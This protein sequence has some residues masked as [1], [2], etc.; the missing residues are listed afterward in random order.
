VADGVDVVVIGG[1][2]NGLVAG[3][4][5]AR[6]RRSVLVIEQRPVP[7]GA[8]VTTEFSPGFRAP[9]LSHSLGPIDRAVIRELALDGIG[10]GFVSPEPALTTLGSRGELI[11]FHKDPVRTAESIRAVSPPDADAWPAFVESVGRVGAVAAAVTRRP[12][13]PLDQMTAADAWS[14]LR[15]ARQA[16]GLGRRDLAR[17]IRWVPQAVADLT[18]EWFEHDLV[19]AAVS[20][21]AIY[22]NPAGPRSAGTG[23]M[24]LQ[25]LAADPLPV[26]SGVTVAGGPGALTAALARLAGDAGAVIRTG[27]RVASIV[28]EGGVATGVALDGGETVTARCVLATVDPRQTFLDLLTADDLPTSFRQR[29]AHYRARGV[30]AKIHLALSGPPIFPAFGDDQSM[31]GRLLVAPDLDYLERAFDAVKYGACSPAPWLEIAIPSH[32]D[33]S[34][35]PAGCHVMS[36]VVHFA[37]YT[38]RSGTWQTT[39]EMLYRSVLQVLGSVCPRIESLVVGREI[40]TPADL[41]QRWGLTGGHIF[42]GETALDQAWIARPQLGWARYRTPV[43]GLWLGGAGSHPG[44][45]LTGLPGL[46][47]ARAVDRALR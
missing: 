18:G 31:R 38:L 37:P 8:A 39:A 21:H 16:R 29:I 24:L 4:W 45:G 33:P 34:F 32:A 2:L 27:A 22:G 26:G 46:L 42:H 36:I 41:E 9:T 14:L 20:A 5:L 30:T 1:G 11:S 6:R 19:K 35:A 10:L 12:P 44:G 47:A 43:T 15:L 40:L 17:L 7:G 25:R 13:P 28:T 3:T 23:G